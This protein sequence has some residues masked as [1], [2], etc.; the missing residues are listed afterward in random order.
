MPIATISTTLTASDRDAEK[1]TRT[2]GATS[3][4]AANS[5]PCGKTAVVRGDGERAGQRP[6]A[7]GG[8]EQAERAR[9]AGEDVLGEHGQERL[10]RE[11]QHVHRDR[12]EQ[13]RARDRARPRGGEAARERGEDRR[14]ARRRRA[15]DPPAETE[16]RRETD[17]ERGEH[18]RVARGGPEARQARAGDDRA[19]HL[20]DLH[21][22]RLERHGLRHPRGAEHAEERRPSRGEVEAPE[23]AERAFERDEQPIPG[24][25]DGEHRK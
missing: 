1:A 10:V 16:R 11:E 5:R 4:A 2:N 6:D 14:R 24:G 19:H 13:D 7:V 20:R 22:H 18:P 15:L 21:R 3:T 25:V 23:D 17:G 9:P 8:D 12:D